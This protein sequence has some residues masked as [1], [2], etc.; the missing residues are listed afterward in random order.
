MTVNKTMI[1]KL[2]SN[3]PAYTGSRVNPNWKVIIEAIGQEDQYLALLIEEVRKQFSMRTGY[4]P[5]IDR[6]ASNVKVDRP[7]L[8]GMDDTTFRKYVP[9]MSYHPK[10]VKLIIDK[11]LDVFFFRDS[12]TAHIETSSF[13]PYNIEDSWTLEYMV[14]DAYHE[15]VT[16]VTSDFANIASATADEVAASINRQVTHSFAVS[17]Y[18]PV[19]NVNT[20]RLFTNTIGS[21]GSIVIEGGQSNVVLKF[22]DYL[23]DVAIGSNT[24]WTVTKIGDEL[25]F[26]YTGGTDP[27][28]ADLLDGDIA[29]IDISGISGSFPIKNISIDDEKFS[30]INYFGQAGV[31]TQSSTTQFRFL[32]PYKANIALQKK[33]AAMWET[34]P[35][36]LV[37]EMPATPPVV[38]RTLKGAIHL[39]GLVRTVVDRSSDTSL[40]L[41][42]ASLWPQSG[43]FWL[44]ELRE[45]KHR[46]ATS[47]EDTQSSSLVNANLIGELERYEYTSKIGN[48]L[49]GIT[50]NLPAL[51]SLNQ[52]DISTCDRSSDVLTIVTSDPHTFVEDEYVCISDLLPTVFGVNG[53]YQVESVISPLSFTVTSVGTDGSATPSTG[54]ARVERMGM[55]NS[56]SSAILTDSQLSAITGI[57][58][59]YLWDQSAP[60]VLSSC[61]GV[62]DEQ[63]KAGSIK[64]TLQLGSND[65]SVESGYVIFEYGT[66]DQEGPIK[67]L[68]KTSGQVL[69]LD[70]T[71][72]FQKN[73]AVG[74]NLIMLRHF[75][76]HK[77]SVTGAEYATY[78][79]DPL[80]VRDNLEQMILSVKSVGFYV[81]FLVRYPHQLFATIDVYRSGVDPG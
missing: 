50:P 3:M 63:I 51:A 38:R 44:K 15:R 16:F 23:D 32:R 28:I 59:A 55:T 67:Y 5:Y 22:N 39:N 72:T 33:R 71:Y 9:I 42:D 1:D 13:E 4:R 58:G 11:L 64:K 74:C 68:F 29:L 81:D 31:Y 7:R 12:T 54:N 61:V 24:Q 6:L 60:F 26:A 48:V 70:P 27:G 77:I 17:H 36:K 37:I 46:Y 18:N 41:D 47:L 30:L 66:S 8:M 80:V 25:T 49:T 2:H 21:K 56:G 78:V 73:H 75:G 79:T 65:I 57:T 20:I 53:S 35:N 34:G 40:T 10:Q 45:L 43:T 14:D 19:L 62:T 52:V 76:P 69:A